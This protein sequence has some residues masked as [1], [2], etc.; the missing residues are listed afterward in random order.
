MLTQGP[1]LQFENPVSDP[2]TVYVVQPYG[3]AGVI[4]HLNFDL[5]RGHI[6]TS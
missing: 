6:W 5:Y 4:D 3:I 1:S 2:Y